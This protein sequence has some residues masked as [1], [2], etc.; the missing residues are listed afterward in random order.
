MEMD[1]PASS[2]EGG[3]SSVIRKWMSPWG[4]AAFERMVREIGHTAYELDCIGVGSICAACA[5]SLHESFSATDIEDKLASVAKTFA[6]NY[7]S[8][9]ELLQERN[10]CRAVLKMPPRSFPPGY[11]L[12]LNVSNIDFGLESEDDC[13]DLSWDEYETDDD[14]AS[15]LE[16][17]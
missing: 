11:Q 14:D 2:A 12:D 10:E 5:D 6:D 17:N 3:E 16:Y 13:C 8:S 7:I 15:G 1:E 4:H 9:M